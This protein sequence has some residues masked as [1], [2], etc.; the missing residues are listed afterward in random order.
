[1][2]ATTV[3]EKV[4]HGDR[5]SCRLVHKPQVMDQAHISSRR[6][7]AWQG[8]ASYSCPIQ[9]P[10][11]LLNLILSTATKRS[12]MKYAPCGD[13]TGNVFVGLP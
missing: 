1:M 7:V 6:S 9:G 12:A 4:A 11:V 13:P 3:C 10:Y 2:L 8:K 5:Q